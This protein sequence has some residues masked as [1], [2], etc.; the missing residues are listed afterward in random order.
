MTGQTPSAEADCVIREILTSGRPPCTK[1][2]PTVLG[3]TWP[4]GGCSLQPTARKHKRTE[5]NSNSQLNCLLFVFFCHRIHFILPHNTEQANHIH[6]PSPRFGFA[7]LCR[8]HLSSAQTRQTQGWWTSSWK[9]GSAGR[10]FRRH[11]WETNKNVSFWVHCSIFLLF[12]SHIL[13]GSAVN[14]V[15]KL[16]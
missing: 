15:K 11:T 9:P 3:W 10:R 14:A 6:L 8:F 4:A 12:L 2:P 5:E 7:P 16:F 1:T 13:E